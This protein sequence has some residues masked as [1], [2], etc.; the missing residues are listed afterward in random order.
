MPKS[1][2][3]SCKVILQSSSVSSIAVIAV[4]F[5]VKYFV[6]KDMQTRRKGQ[7]NIAE[8]TLSPSLCAKPLITAL[9]F[10]SYY[11]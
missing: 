11:L 4:E 5:T 9:L 3:S 6:F 10:V 1:K 7:Y 8:L 2:R